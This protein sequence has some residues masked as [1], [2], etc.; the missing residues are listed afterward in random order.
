MWPQARLSSKVRPAC[1][2][3]PFYLGPKPIDQPKNYLT[4]GR[5]IPTA[6]VKDCVIVSPN[7]VEILGRVVDY[8]EN[9][10]VHPL[11]G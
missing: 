8:W 9:I 7:T 10:Q 4:C 5:Q 6:F 3:Q 11:D 1:E 2:S